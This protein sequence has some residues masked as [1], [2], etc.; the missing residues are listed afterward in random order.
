MI[1]NYINLHKRVLIKPMKQL[2]SKFNLIITLICAFQFSVFAINTDNKSFNVRNFGAVGDGTTLDSPAINRTI[3]A[4]EK[5]GG[6]KVIIPVGKYLCGSIHIKSNINLYIEKGAVIVADNWD[7]PN[8][9][10]TESITFPV[11]QDSGHSFFHNSLIWGENLTNVTISGEGMIDGTGLTKKGSALDK[12]IGFS[13]NKQVIPETPME[14]TFSANKSIALKWCKN[15]FIKDITIFNG[16]WFGILV[17]GC[18]DMVIDNLTI[19]TNRDGIDI[20][21]CKNVVVKNC[22]VNSPYDDAICPKSTY[23]L[24]EQRLT[25]NLLITNCEVSG[26]ETGTLLN[27]T[28]VPNKKERTGR[29]KF[30]TESSGGFRNCKVTNCRFYSCCGL[31]IEEVDGGIC[32]NITFDGIKMYDSFRYGIYIVTGCRN[33]TPNLLTDSRMRN[34]NIKNVTID[35]SN[36]SGMQIFGM[37]DKPI[38]GIHLSNIIMNCN[39]GGTAED[40]KII[41]NELATGYPDPKH[42]GNVPAYGI[43]ARHVK[44]LDMKNITY[45]LK[46]D[47]VRSAGIF[48]DVDGLTLDNFKA[49]VLTGVKVAEFKYNVKNVKITNSPGLK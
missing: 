31:A 45:T 36:S 17:T 48:V 41:P 27:G 24:G 30:G 47:D 18:D 1:I 33:R 20:D 21:C 34:I 22:K 8:F 38:Q 28:K 3:E 25:E 11:Y 37:P 35:G 14:P 12:K 7:S 39:G 42:T 46:S 16:G 40:A 26:Y 29:V 5:A 10:P 15:V 49:Q 4:A 13:N 43:F 9:D 32:E 19:D 23:A 6:G 44:D 2:N